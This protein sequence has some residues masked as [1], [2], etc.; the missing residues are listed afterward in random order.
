MNPR[1]ARAA[2]ACASW[3][4]HVPR[5]TLRNVEYVDP[6]FA[7]T[8]AWRW[9][10][11][12]GMLTR[13]AAIQLLAW[14]ILRLALVAAFRDPASTTAD[15]PLIALTGFANDLA[16]ALTVML[17]WLFALGALWLRWL[18]RAWLQHG[19]VA[20]LASASV[21]DAFVQFF[22]FEEYDARYNHLALDY[23][24]YPHEVLGNIFA[25]Y[26]VPLF[27]ALA[28]IIGVTL[29]IA[30]RDLRSH[31]RQT[32]TAA[33]RA[34][35]IAVAATLTLI[36]GA[37]WAA[38]PASIWS[39]R[40]SNELA[41]NGWTQLVRAY[42]SA[43]LDYDAYY[44]MVPQAE[45]STRV[46]RWI[47][48]SAPERGLM[49]HFGRR[50]R[51]QGD[52]LDVVVILEESL[53]SDFSTR[54]GPPSD[55]QEAVTPELDRWSREGLSFTN[56]IANGNRTVRG[57]EGVLCSFLPL[58]GDAIVKRDRSE[59]VASIARV[60]S[61]QGY[62]T[63][64][65]Y[66]GYGLFD[67]VEP[68]MKANGFD[69]FIGESDFP[70]D[71]F[72]TIWGVADEFV[73]DEM[74]LRQKAAH[75]SGRRWLG[76]A[77]TV[78]NHKPFDIPSGRITWAQG[79][80]KRRGAVLYA[81]W[82]LGRYLA[83]ARAE[84][85]LDHTV[86]LV[87]GDHGARVYGAEEI[88]VTSYRVPAAIFTPDTT[89]RGAVIDRL[90]SQVDL[91]PTLLSLAGVEYDA[92]FFGDDLLGLPDEGGR[93]FVNH[94]RSVGVL[95]DTALV[96]LGLHRSITLYRRADRH[97]FVFTRATSETAALTQL[98]RDTEAV[99][100]TAYRRY[101]ERTFRLPPTPPDRAARIRPAD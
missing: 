64:F 97:S 22:F 42:W 18:D 75:A 52:P 56:V 3:S 54:F 77:L 67:N 83:R 28:G 2:V 34:R 90:A 59:N 91:A 25:S 11:R 72:R 4:V 6:A 17:P 43:H 99:F 100:Q 94:N 9:N 74:I 71:A 68:F 86:V 15:V 45:A 87:V 12:M 66:G 63:T 33:D 60:L 82:A 47:H 36:A 85:L 46:A 20:M 48:Q 96:A 55:G 62:E 73:F 69:S 10:R 29:T 5:T 79:K 30:S 13:L 16:A 65:L 8:F 24:V 95:T 80:S 61:A 70:A 49:R 1:H 88:P 27:A 41:L 50:G 89:H 35:G 21:F 40:I 53:G 37:A 26:N 93:A 98:E 92:P 44:A 39:S 7:D 57:L 23:L 58:P 19:L 78:S 51:P 31:T 81:D 32:W 14:S 101:M 76:T 38:V 84:G